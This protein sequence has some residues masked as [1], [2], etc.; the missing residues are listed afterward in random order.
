MKS[1]L[2]VF[3]ATIALG[4]QS[5]LANDC[6]GAHNKTEKMDVSILAKAILER[7]QDNSDGEILVVVGLGNLTY[8][9]TRHNVGADL[10]GKMA[11]AVKSESHEVPEHW[12]EYLA[13]DE[14]DAQEYVDFSGASSPRRGDGLSVIYRV[15][16]NY[17]LPPNSPRMRKL[18][19][20]RPYYDINESGHFIS[21]L[22]AETGLRPDQFLVVVDDLTLPRNQVTLSVGKPD[23]KA[24]AHNGLKSINS[25]LGT[26]AYM[27]LR[28]GVSNPKVEKV[29]VSRTDWVLG[30][31]PK[32]DQDIL[33]SDKQVEHFIDLVSNLQS[34]VGVPDRQAQRDVQAGSQILKA[35][36]QPSP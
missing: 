1:V 11:A 10:V 24:D 31:L 29:D 36:N 19:F 14:A 4:S 33:F 5:A 21:A 22:K 17:M 27:R 3:F 8:E 9:G 28:L 32:A 12:R 26:G 13:K 6:A 30:H 15:G 2:S 16:G 23:G 18:V 20:V 34:R 35:L 7:S 25:A